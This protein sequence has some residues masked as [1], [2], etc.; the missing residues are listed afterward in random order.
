MECKYSVLP[1]LTLTK[2]HAMFIEIYVSRTLRDRMKDDFLLLE[3]GV[4]SVAAYEIKFHALSRHAMQLVTS[5][6][7]RICSFINRLN[8]E[9]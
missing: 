3:Q 7:E 8:F 4:M 9:L 1:P 5:E 6:E 2:F